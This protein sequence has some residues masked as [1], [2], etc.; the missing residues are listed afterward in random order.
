MLNTSENIAFLVPY[1]K[2]LGPSQRFRVDIYFKA[3]EEAGL[4]I[5]YHP[6]MDEEVYNRFYDKGAWGMKIWAVV[7]GVFLRFLLMFRL[8]SFSKVF[9]QR[10][11]AP[12]GPPF[13][14]WVITKLWKKPLI[15]DIDDAIWLPNY[16]L[17][18][19]S[20]HQLKMYSKVDS[21]MK[22]SSLIIAGNDFLAERGRQFN[23]NVI[24]IPTIVDTQ[25]YHF[26]IKG[27]RQSKAKE[28][29]L[30]WTGTHSTNRFIEHIAPVLER[31]AERHEFRLLI[32]SNKRP[33]MTLKN[34]E[35]RD[36]SLAKEISDLREMDI[37]LMPMIADFD[38]AEGK[39]GF[40]AIQ[41]MAL[42]IPV[43]IGGLGVNSQIVQHGVNGYICDTME[44]WE[45][46]L[47]EV[48]SNPEKLKELAKKGR[49]TI[50]AKYSLESQAKRFIQSLTS[51][52]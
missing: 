35:Y 28:I 9:I 44:E 27:D 14:E 25:D 6:F 7:K 47:D 30:G 21:I 23:A 51:L 19:A 40:K 18:N 49:E 31:L 1:P 22:W 2:G 5:E 11:A 17:A 38:F 24:I 32:I 8:G 52:S 46:S 15:Y 50:V 20:L 10:E 39:C 37:G 41:F 33:D 26:P 43:I 29:T 36:W 12:L 34:L 42:E 45:R 13:F 16:A 4:N 48:L 3:M